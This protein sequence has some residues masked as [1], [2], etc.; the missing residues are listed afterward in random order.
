MKTPK[1]RFKGFVDDWEQRKLG[2]VAEFNPKADLPDI[3]EYVDLE[4]V[5]GVEMV[6]HRQESKAT[7]PSRA[8]RLAQ[9]GDLFYQTVR[10]YQKN[11]Y[12]FEKVDKHYVFSTGYAQIRPYQ[13]GYFLLSLVQNDD[14]VKIVLDNC[15]GTSYPAINVNDL[16]KI[17]AKFPFRTDEQVQI[18]C[19]FR[20]IDHL[21]TLHQRKCDQTKKLKKYMLQ[22]MFPQDGEKTPKI[23]FDGFTDDWE[24][25]KLG[26]ISN[27]FSGGTPSVSVKE[28]YN[29]S[30]PFIRSAEINSD[31]TE[32]FITENG[33]NN[34]SARLVNQGDILYAMYGATSGEVGRSKQKGAINQA[35]LAIIPQQGYDSEFITQWL[36]KNKKSIV[37][38][39]LQGGQG[40]L[41]ARIVKNLIV[42]YPKYIEQQKIGQYFSQLDY[43]ITLHQCKCNFINKNSVND[44]EQR[45][46]E[47]VATIRRGLT[48]KPTIIVDNGVRVLRS[49]NINED[50]FVVGDDDIFV[51]NNVVN[52]PYIKNGDILITS[53][54]GSSRLV[55]KH[56]IIRNLPKNSAVHGGFML[57][58]SCSNPEFLNASMSS[59][60]YSKFIRI[61]VAG[62]NGAIGNIN[63]NDLDSQIFLSPNEIEQQKIGQYFSQLDYLITL[64]Q[65]KSKIYEMIMGITERQRKPLKIDIKMQIK[66]FYIV[67]L[68]YKLEIVYSF[69]Y[70]II[71]LRFYKVEGNNDKLISFKDKCLIF[72][73]GIVNIICFILF[74]HQYL[75][76]I[77]ILS[78]FVKINIF[79]TRRR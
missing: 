71:R 54:N 39:Y 61:Y 27:S 11:N 79:I 15:T 22:N 32:L 8:Q 45:K 6:S 49:S 53:A 28:Y 78:I 58:A 23:R 12:L 20:S 37:T 62:G 70:K 41:S 21:I 31:S 77:K 73:I 7:A 42:D 29:G 34:S 33:L 3:F 40:N 5:V 25:R 26:E 2:E 67:N 64:H 50:E 52:I 30:I 36:K 43:L 51:E 1:I 14:F 24:Q 60:W 19:F 16:A 18:G 69:Y 72:I 59:Q 57:I 65:W 76:C 55:G 74:Y 13:D 66:V 46:L 4:S 75:I 35:I 47:E 10:P 38:T 44:W 9:K 48:Y 68:V 17:K 63:K 56:A